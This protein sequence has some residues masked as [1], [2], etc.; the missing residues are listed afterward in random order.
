MSKIAEPRAEQQARLIAMPRRERSSAIAKDCI[1]LT[2]RRITFCIVSVLHKVK[3]LQRMLSP[4][5]SSM[6]SRMS[7]QTKL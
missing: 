2:V 3:T 6:L 1:L 4:V 7:S 5:L